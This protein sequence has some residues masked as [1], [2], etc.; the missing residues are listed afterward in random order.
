MKDAVI[1]GSGMGGLSAAIT[2]ALMKYQVTVIEKNDEPGGLM[3][4][5]RRAG[6]DCPVGVHYLGSLGEGESLRRLF[7]FLGITDRVPVE[8]MG[9]NGV[10]DRYVFDDVTFDLPVGIDAFEAN[11]RAAFPREGT[12]IDGIMTGLKVTA[13]RMHSLN[14]LFDPAGNLPDF[15]LFSPMGEIFRRLGCS[16]SLCGVLGVS[17]Y[18]MGVPVFQ[19]P[20]I[21][22]YMV[23]SSYLYSSWRPAC[24]STGMADACTA[25][26]G[27]LGGEVLCGDPAVQVLVKDKKA[28]GVR[29]A[30]GREITAPVVIAAV[31]PKVLVPMLPE[32]AVRPVYRKRLEGLVDTR[33]IFS[34]NV[35]VDADAHPAL[36]HNVYRL[37]RLESGEIEDLLYIQL[38]PSGREG[39]NALTMIEPADFED[40]ERWKDTVSGRRPPEYREM[41]AA[42]ARAMIARAETLLGPLKNASIIDTYSPLTLRDW[43]ST[44]RGA[45]YGV[46]RSADQLRKMSSLNRTPV[47]GLY[48]AG[49]SV[50]APGILGTIIG[51]LMTVGLIVGPERFRREVTVGAC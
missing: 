2:L 34:A 28:E 18:L 27:E 40:W 36:D 32:G 20:A 50:Q 43:V 4:G 23:L 45:T 3:R 10:I 49:Q 42:V 29:L 5:Y 48:M 12:A 14:F 25:R 44:P 39:V 11:L 7:D 37:N 24:G 6:V 22:Y 41:K 16:P 15:E 47:A 26:L 31:H 19:C 13:D 8:P 51:S 33:S 38:R 46:L 35:T 21:Y 17:S 30:S 9:R 1:I